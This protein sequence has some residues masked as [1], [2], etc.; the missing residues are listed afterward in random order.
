MVN[1]FCSSPSPKHILISIPTVKDLKPETMD[2]V[3]ASSQA[4]TELG[5]KVS[6]P[7]SPCH[8]TEAIPEFDWG[9]G[10][11]NDPRDNLHCGVVSVHSQCDSIDECIQARK[12][13]F[14]TPLNYRFDWTPEI[15]IQ[16]DLPLQ[17]GIDVDMDDAFV[18]LG[19]D[20]TSIL[21]MCDEIV[22]KEEIL[23]LSSWLKS[24]KDL[25]IWST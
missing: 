12:D 23:S 5:N 14:D 1:S 18:S 21:D 9:E 24:N 7:I 20:D 8:T 13:E 16:K 15:M 11:V 19:G 22:D 3:N 25:D 10:V 4:N 2:D 17:E 6:I